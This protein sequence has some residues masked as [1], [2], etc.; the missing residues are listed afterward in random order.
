MRGNDS[1]AMLRG[2]LIAAAIGLCSAAAPAYAVSFSDVTFSNGDWT[3]QN[4][5]YAETD[6][7]ATFAAVQVTSGGNAGD[8]RQTTLNY[9]GPNQGIVVGHLATNAVYDPSLGAIGSIDFA[10]DLRFF[11]FPGTGPS[12]S[13]AVGYGALIEQGGQY[14][15]AP[16]VAT[17]TNSWVHFAF[18]TTAASFNSPIGHP[19]FSAT[20]A[21]ITLGYYTANGTGH[22]SATTTIS[23][24]D[25]WSATINPAAVPEPATWAMLLLGFGSMGAILRRRRG[26]AAA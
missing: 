3:I 23:G 2:A 9:S 16:A 25:N 15:R 22:A 8:Y 5:P 13:N 20:G 6:P 11:N 17:V 7:G 10:F 26:L 12:P 14:Y 19:D 4:L 21:P 18:S 24:I 1:T